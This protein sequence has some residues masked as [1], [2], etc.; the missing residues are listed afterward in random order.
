MKQRPRPQ[1]EEVAGASAS[2][3]L[4]SEEVLDYMRV[5]RV[6]SLERVKLGKFKEVGRTVVAMLPIVL[7]SVTSAFVDP[8]P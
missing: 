8:V 3:G 4:S 5:R 7:P 2:T 1:A 6:S